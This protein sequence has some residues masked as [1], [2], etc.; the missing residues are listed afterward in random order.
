ML[1][2]MDLEA[3]LR[4]A[5]AQQKRLIR[6]NACQQDTQ[7]RRGTR[8]DIYESHTFRVR[9]EA[10]QRAEHR[11][12]PPEWK[13]TARRGAAFRGTRIVQVGTIEKHTTHYLGPF[14]EVLV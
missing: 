10:R 13:S 8:A 5:I 11:D 3:R 7:W 2:N 1:A 12:A 4:D 9:D 6:E 14:G